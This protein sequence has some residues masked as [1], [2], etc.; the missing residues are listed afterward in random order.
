[1]IPEA[2]SRYLKIENEQFRS[3]QELKLSRGLKVK[4]TAAEE[5]SKP[6]PVEQ[7]LPVLDP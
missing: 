4:S 7:W 3:V 6:W 1:M 5:K 2:E